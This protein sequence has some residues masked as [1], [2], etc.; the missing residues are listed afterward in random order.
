MNVA[1]AELIVTWFRD[2]EDRFRELLRTVPITGQTEGIFLPTL[3]SI[4]LEACSVLDTVFRDGY[5]P[6]AQARDANM[7]LY[8]VY[9]DPLYRLSSTKSIIYQYPLRLLRPFEN[10][11]DTNGMY[12]ALE[13]W[14]NYNS[15]KHDRIANYELSTFRTA[16]NALCALHQVIAKNP[17]F[18]ESLIRHNMICFGQWGQ[19]YALEVI[20]ANDGREELTLMVESELFGTPVGFNE[21]PDSPDRINPWRY[22]YGKKLAQFLGRPIH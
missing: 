5:Q 18:L 16:L 20:R 4:I 8:A 10:W 19:G 11:L 1:G 14:Q 22:A 9:Y 3:S 21:F 13:W 7:P 15:L 6:A 12:Q 2:L 17:D